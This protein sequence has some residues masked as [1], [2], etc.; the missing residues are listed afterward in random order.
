MAK[1]N[2]SWFKIGSFF[3][4]GLLVIL[5]FM[6]LGFGI[7]NM[8]DGETVY[9]IACILGGVLSGAASVMVYKNYQ[10]KSNSK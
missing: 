1:C 6:L 2:F 3:G 4:A 9:G 7:T 8:V 5:C 10:K